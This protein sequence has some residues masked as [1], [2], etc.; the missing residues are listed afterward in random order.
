MKLLPFQK[1]DFM[2]IF[3]AMAGKPV[4]IRL[5]DPPLHEFVDAGRRADRRTLRARSR[6]PP[7]KIKT[8]IAQ[9]HELNPML[10]HR[11]CRLGIAYP[12]IT[13]MQARAILEAAA[14]LH[15]AEG[16]GASRR[17][18][19]RSSGHVNEFANQEAIIRRVADEVQKE[20]KVKLELHGRHDDR[21]PARGARRRQDRRDAPSSSASA[22]T[23]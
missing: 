18:W 17:S 22:P 15:E 12:E 7:E 8:R 13:E 20:Y 23:T 16:Q 14:E 9:L 10:G 19:S 5:L 1:A 4:T 3:K 2:G 21:D 6:R 11:G